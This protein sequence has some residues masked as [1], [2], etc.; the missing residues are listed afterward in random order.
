MFLDQVVFQDQRFFFRLGDDVVK[1]VDVGDQLCRLV[2][3]G[4]TKIGIDPIEKI[5]GLA[6]IDDRTVFVFMQIDTRLFR[7]CR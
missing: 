4:T 2:V 7:E 5:D 1:I 6:D 3:M